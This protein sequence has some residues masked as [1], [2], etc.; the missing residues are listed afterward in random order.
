L[1]E[2][3]L[4]I[5]I[6]AMVST[7]TYATFTIVIGGWRRSVALADTLQRGDFIMDQLVMALRSAY[8]PDT[9]RATALY[10]FR[11]EHGGSGPYNS[12]VVSWVKLGGAL[13]GDDQTYAGSPHRVVFSVRDD[14]EGRRAA[15]VT[16][17]QIFGQM[18]DFREEDVPPVFLSDR[19]TGFRCRAAYRKI[20]D[21]IDWMDEWEQTNRLPTA[22]EL[23]LYLTP[24]A[25]DAEPVEIKRVLGIPVAP[26][27]W[28]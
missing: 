7:I 12:D 8:Y 14:E 3:M 21:E 18:E 23:T 15:A 27:S 22:V 24:P 6:L 5:V 10:G 26:L 2:L 1:L 17:W 9:Q 20:E 16:A 4:A 19:V 28:R 13:V 25:E 11:H